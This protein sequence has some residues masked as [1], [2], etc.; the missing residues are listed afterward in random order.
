LP[1]IFIRGPTWG[2]LRAGEQNHGKPLLPIGL[3][4]YIPK[5]EI[6]TLYLNTVPFG[7]NIFGIEVA[8]ESV[9]Q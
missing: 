2:C 8:S 1:K 9:F 3:K 5:E 7:E 4:K 6:L